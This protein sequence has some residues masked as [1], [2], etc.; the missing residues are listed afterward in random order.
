MLGRLRRFFESPDPIVKVAAG[1]SEPEAHMYRELLEGNGVPA[2]AKNMNVLSV[3]YEA[4]SLSS[5]VDLWV[6]RSDFARARELLEPLLR[7]EQLAPAEE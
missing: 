4:G 5:D 1:M 3:T 7:P 6:R 2:M